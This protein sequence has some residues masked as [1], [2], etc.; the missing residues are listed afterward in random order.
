MQSIYHFWI[1]STVS[2]FDAV[3]VLWL[4]EEVGAT[5]PS[6]PLSTPGSG[7]TLGGLSAELGPAGLGGSSKPQSTWPQNTAPD[8]EFATEVL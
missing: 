6:S 3:Q 1:I 5:T 4:N 8:P 2:V 7:P